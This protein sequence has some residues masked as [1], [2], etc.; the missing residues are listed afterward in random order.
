M[1][2]LICWIYFILNT[3]G[4]ESHD[5]EA[6]EKNIYIYHNFCILIFM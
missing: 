5:M 3:A 4:L 2:K 6:I 1:Q